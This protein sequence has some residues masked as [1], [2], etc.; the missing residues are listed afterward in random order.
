MEKASSPPKTGELVPTPTTPR[1]NASATTR[2]MAK[3]S[4][5]V[6]IG[7]V[8]V[9]KERKKIQNQEK[10]REASLEIVSIETDMESETWFLI[11]EQL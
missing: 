8:S 7:K 1:A 11:D 6:G 3:A 10:P 4:G 5:Q 9:L 2:T